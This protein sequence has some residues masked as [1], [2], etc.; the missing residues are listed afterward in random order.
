MLDP[1]DIKEVDEFINNWWA[2][3]KGK[4]EPWNRIK[5]ALQGSGQNSAELKECCMCKRTRQCYKS[6]ADQWY[7]QECVNSLP[8]GEQNKQMVQFCL[9]DRSWTQDDVTAFHNGG[10]FIQYADL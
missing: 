6:T 8:C 9:A 5:K 10:N 2:F 3:G 4:F 1:N 7:C